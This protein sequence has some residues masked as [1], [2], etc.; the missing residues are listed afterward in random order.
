[1]LMEDAIK[2]WGTETK[3]TESPYM[4]LA[5]SL[6]EVL[7]KDLGAVTHVDGT[8]RIQTLN[9]LDNAELFEIISEFKK[10]TGIGVL[11]NTSLNVKGQPLLN[12]KN[13][14]EVW[15]KM[16]GDKILC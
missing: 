9:K 4:L 14:I 15:E 11:L 8:A 16:Y 5:P 12:D 1:M 3:P 6:S 7:R 10:L 2:F 13:D